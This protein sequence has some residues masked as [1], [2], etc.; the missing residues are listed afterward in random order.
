M[1]AYQM[2]HIGLAEN[3]LVGISHFPELKLIRA[4]QILAPCLS[5]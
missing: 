2:P 5:R 1:L 3:C 4:D